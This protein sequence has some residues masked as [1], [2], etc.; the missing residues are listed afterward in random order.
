MRES[1][2]VLRSFR[3]PARM[4]NAIIILVVALRSG[5]SG[6][7]WPGR[8]NVWATARRGTCFARGLQTGSPAAAGA[9]SAHEWTS[10]V[11]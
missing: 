4:K 2:T 10:R 1:P 6:G 11:G 8:S 7:V 5:C 9:A 3:K